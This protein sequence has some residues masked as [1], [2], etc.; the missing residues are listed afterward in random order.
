M[1]LKAI[2]LGCLTMMSVP[3]LAQ[4]TTKTDAPQNSADNL[5]EKRD[6]KATF[7]AYGQID[8][9]QPVSGD[10]RYNGML[11]VHRLVAFFGYN[12]SDRVQFV[13]EIEVEHVIEVYVEQAFINYK[14][15]DFI[16]L[17]GGLLL[18]PMGIINEY[19]EPPTFNGVERPNLDSRIIPTTWRELGAGIYGKVNSAN[20]KY[21]LY[22]LN[23]F[24]GYNGKANFNGNNG[25][26]SGRQKGAESFMSGPDIAGKIDYYGIRGLK[27]GLAGYVGRSESTLYNGI[28]KDNDAALAMADSST[29]GIRMV[30][31]DARYNLKGF[32]ARGQFVYADIDDAGI[33]NTFTGSDLGS[34][35]MGYYAELG[36]DVLSFCETNKKLVA[37]GRYETY[38]THYKVPENTNLNKAYNR[39]DYTFGLG[40]Y[41]VDN[42]VFKADY[43][44]F[45]NETDADPRNQ[46]NFGIGFWFY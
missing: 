14:L 8:Y 5:M 19:H 34:A 1:N 23:G 20:L 46:I 2:V 6:H 9:N 25:F 29:V 42:V 7:G 21:Q 37:F 39:T 31:L 27:I 45:D 10:K 32:E 13:S 38:F 22:A 35:M 43:Q 33:Y 16:S 26:R 18:I 4:D 15:N 3:L 12:F 41:P 24:N 30:G 11:D 36:F 28:E 40:F 44:I 17:R